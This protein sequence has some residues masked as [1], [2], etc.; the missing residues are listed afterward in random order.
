MKKIYKQLEQENA[1]LT[2]EA[3]R[4]REACRLAYAFFGHRMGEPVTCCLALGERPQAGEVCRA[5]EKALAPTE[6]PAKE[7]T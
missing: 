7:G 6:K 3:G 2:A 1:K 5:L 4:M